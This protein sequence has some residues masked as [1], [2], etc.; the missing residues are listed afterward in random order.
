MVNLRKKEIKTFEAPSP[1]GPYS[2]AVSVGELVFVSGQVPQ[3]SDDN[4]SADKGGIEEE[5]TQV[6]DNVEKILEAAGL[7]LDN[8]VKVDVYL[9]DL[10]DFSKMNK[11]YSSRFSAGVKPARAVIGA[12]GLPKGAN[13][14]ISCI[15]HR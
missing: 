5:T 14:E 9:R 7:S 8:V 10:D 11:I 12:S 15:A 3:C 4:I 6:L 13:I 1:V 2:Q